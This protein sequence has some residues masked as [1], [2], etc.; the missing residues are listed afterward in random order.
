MPSLRRAVWL[1]AVS[2]IAFTV[3]RLSSRHSILGDLAVYRAEGMAIRHNDNL[4]AHLEGFHSLG[5]YPPFAAVMFVTLTLLP[6]GLVE[7]LCLIVNV[8]LLA[9]VCYLGC[10]L[11]GLRGRDALV[12]VLVFTAVATW[13]EPIFTTF[14]YGQINLLLLALVLWDFTLPETSR[15]RGIGT[16]IAAGWKVTPGI[17]IVY[18]L[19]TKRF[20]AALVAAVTFLGTVAF[21]GIFDWHDTW[22]YWTHYLFQ[23]SRVGHVENPVNQTVR[24]LA[25]RAG[26]S[27]HVPPWVVLLIGLVLIAGLV[28]AWQAYLRFGDAWGLPAAAV[29]GLLVSPISWSH[30]WVWA[31]PIAIVLWAQTRR[32]LYAALAVFMTW[33]VWYVTWVSHRH[34]FALN[35]V[36]V[37]GS[38][39]YILFG[40]GFLALTAYRWSTEPAPASSD[41]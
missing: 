1:L 20:R 21:S 24:G 4:Y 8:L 36:E 31:L 15:W 29:T 14:A 38:G 3:V 35:P 39:L 28:I 6:F 7:V 30:H 9:L 40:L 19:I 11:A 33:C 22:R 10:R 23:L 13:S 34:W 2:L 32:W 41:V 26:Q 27:L 17:L 5:T 18:L 16:G 25:V 12:P 37:A